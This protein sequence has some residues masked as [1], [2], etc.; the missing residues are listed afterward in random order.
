MS[1]Y[2]KSALKILFLN[3]WITYTKY[4]FT[5]KHY[6][7]FVIKQR[8]FASYP[9]IKC[10]FHL[11]IIRF[12]LRKSDFLYSAAMNIK[13]YKNP[14]AIYIKNYF[15][16]SHHSVFVIKHRISHSV[17]YIKCYFRLSVIYFLLKINRFF[18]FSSD[19]YKNVVGKLMMIKNIKQS[20]SCS[21]N[22]KQPP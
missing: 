11:S 12:L 7:I 2:K 14:P 9:Y 1:F 19:K 8:F 3:S 6:F 4:Y 15:T 21:K 18:I 16:L 13:K 17:I 5:P 20:R 22:C 10:Y